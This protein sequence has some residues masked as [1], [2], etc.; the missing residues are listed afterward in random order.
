[1]PLEVEFTDAPSDAD[2][3]AVLDGLKAFN[4]AAAGV[5]SRPLGLFVRD[6]ARVVGG[7]T[8]RTG[9]DWMFVEFLWLADG[10]R[11]R[12][13]GADLIARAEREAAA[14]GCMG[15]WLD[16]FSFQA[17]GFYERQGYAVFGVLEDSPEGGARYFMRKRFGRAAG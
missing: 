15:A 10:F 6:G 3:T 14:R 17:R 12:G 16:T 7:L 4:L 11:G 2:R 1:M 13:L 5:S 8:G 9:A